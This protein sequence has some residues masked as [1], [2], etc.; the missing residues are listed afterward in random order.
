[1]SIL[2]KSAR[3]APREWDQP[4]GLTENLIRN[5]ERAVVGKRRAV[6][7]CVIAILARGHVLI[8]D[9]PGTG[10]TLLVKAL[11]HSLDCSFKRIQFTPDLLPA[12][13]TGASI[14][15]PLLHSFEFRKGPLFANL[16][17]ADELNR[18]PA[19][20]QAALLEAMEERQ[21]TAD[22]EAYALPEPFVLLATQ[23]AVDGEGTF[24][25]PEAQLD[26]FLLRVR[27]GY[28]DIREEADILGRHAERSPLE[29]LRPVLMK[30][31]LLALQSRVEAVYVDATL[32][33]YIARLAAETRAHR[34]AALGAS[35]R[36]SVALMRAAQA[37]A[38]LAGRTY[39]IPDDIKELAAPV[40]AHRLLVAAAA[41]YAGRTA[42]QIVEEALE[43]TAVPSVQR[44]RGARS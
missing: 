31:E 2:P 42:E 8:E 35:P 20:T 36:A 22:G 19:K 6:E 17:L 26:R 23:N 5:I 21:V 40:F 28:P 41:R 34:D 32:R 12:D 30:E 33:E 11:A 43:R 14:Y 37:S 18:T 3:I 10:K 9:V 25:L 16:V 13:V 24:V 38:F 44:E 7:L 4:E 1:M 27:L 29:Y 39:V 15:H